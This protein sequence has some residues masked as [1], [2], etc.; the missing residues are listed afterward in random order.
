VHDKLPSP[1]AVYPSG[2]A[3][4]KQEEVENGED[5]P[6]I[7][8]KETFAQYPFLNKGQVKSS[9]SVPTSGI[10]TLVRILSLSHAHVQEC[11][12]LVSS[13]FGG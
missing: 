13:L 12:F 2:F 4:K 7:H 5:F 1:N 8:A 6:H 11:S 3:S 9:Q 10:L